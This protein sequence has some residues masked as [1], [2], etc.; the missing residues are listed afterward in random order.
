MNKVELTGRLTRDP[1]LRYMQNE[2]NTA[3]AN[4]SIA[5]GRKFKDSSGNYGADFP[6]IVAIGK[7]AEFIE[8]YFKKGN[9]IEIV[10]HIQTGSYTNKDGIKVFT[11]EVAVDEVDFAENKGNNSSNQQS[12]SQPN[13]DGFMNIPDGLDDKLPFN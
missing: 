9:K 4:F 11:T 3:I 7:N 5:V 6:N 10:G 12:A 2:K 1:E 8:K 13:S